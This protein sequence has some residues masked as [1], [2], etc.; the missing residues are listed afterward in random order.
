MK[1]TF[2]AAWCSGV[3]FLSQNAD[4][5]QRI[6]E[7]SLTCNF[8]GW[9][10]RDY[11]KQ[12]KTCTFTFKLLSKSLGHT[13]G[14]SHFAAGM[15]LETDYR[16]LSLMCC[17]IVLLSTCVQACKVSHEQFLWRTNKRGV[18]AENCTSSNGIPS[19]PGVCRKAFWKGPSFIQ[20]EKAA[21]G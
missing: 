10:R 14:D 17:G 20:C 13:A 19:N 1:F 5:L 11:L 16:T 9:I 4:N 21:W 8:K 15:L 12:R 2:K 7:N 18:S 6:L 3:L